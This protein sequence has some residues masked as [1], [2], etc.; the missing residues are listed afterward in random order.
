MSC[1]ARSDDAPGGSSGEFAEEG[2]EAR[3]KG[4]GLC[5][6]VSE[7]VESVI[8]GGEEGTE[9]ARVGE[10]SSHIVV[11]ALITLQLGL[12]LRPTC[13]DEE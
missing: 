10:E 4:S 11:L 2:I 12:R 6:E 13:S 9:T 5:L 3:L 1:N 8:Q 7:E